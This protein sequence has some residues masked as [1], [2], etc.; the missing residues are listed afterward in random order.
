MSGAEPLEPLSGER[1]L[2]LADSPLA[3]AT[4]GGRARIVGEIR[5]A[6]MLGVEPTLLCFVAP[7]DLLRYRGRLRAARRAL[8]AEAGCRVHYV[9][10]S[11][12]RRWRAGEVVAD[13][14]RAAVG[15]AYALRLRARL[16]HTSSLSTA[17]AA[18]KMRGLDPRAR[19][20][21]DIH[22]VVEEGFREGGRRGAGR[23]VAPVERR[24]RGVLEGADAVVLVSDA[25][26]A[27]YRAKYGLSRTGV[28]VV[29]CATD[30]VGCFSEAARATVRGR[31][32]LADRLVFCYVGAAENYQMAPAMCRLFKA[33]HERLPESFLL[34]LS[35]DSEAFRS[36]L[37]EVG[38]DPASFS[39][40]AVPHKRVGELV[41]GADI[42]LMLRDDLVL[43]HVAFPTKF[44][45]YCACG[46]P[47]LTTPH[48]HDVAELV[49][50]AG[51]G[52]IVENPEASLTDSVAG[53]LEKVRRRRT[54]MGQECVRLAE[55]R[56]SW[57]AV[58]PALRSAYAH[59]LGRSRRLG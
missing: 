2:F 58:A 36:V 11:P 54:E 17:A 21:V 19:A 55:K 14:Q 13:A 45:E 22:G 39:I 38:V 16:I 29:P 40:M 48:V 28:A 5:V 25:M 23:Y 46:V 30:L 6:L 12:L 4:G 52:F 1:V 24:E 44:A 9:P 31:M 37:L 26:N 34:I 53:F 15:L 41:I 20:V 49:R 59:A 10:R 7:T 50:A 35:H 47:V 18:L 3:R 57:A 56:L 33:I 27:H 43:N 42:A 32:G 51:V 8:E